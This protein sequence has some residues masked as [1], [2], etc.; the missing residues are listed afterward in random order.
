MKTLKLVVV[1]SLFVVFASSASARA[2]T[3]QRHTE[4]RSAIKCTSLR[5]SRMVS[6]PIPI[7]CS[8]EPQKQNDEQQVGEAYRNYVAAWKAKDITTLQKLIAD[9]Y[10]TLDPAGKVSTKDQE[11]ASAK[12]D[13]TYD[14]MVVDDIHTRLLE[15][16]AIVCGRLLAKGRGGDGKPFSVRVRFLAVLVKR[17]GQ[18]Q[19]IA[20]QSAP[21]RSS[22][23]R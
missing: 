1:A 13:P 3:G 12:S 15:A 14:E 23:Q 5:V 10:M 9:D 17:S 19:L 16:T 4:G 21:M 11:I 7:G 2:Q 18:W 8:E 22:E 20:D 6:I